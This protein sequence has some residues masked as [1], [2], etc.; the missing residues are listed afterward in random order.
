MTGK[1]KAELD[2]GLATAALKTGD[3]GLARRA[4]E[5]GL[6]R[7]PGDRGL[8]RLLLL[9]QMSLEDGAAARHTEARLAQ[10]K[11]DGDTFEVL[12]AAALADNRIGDARTLVAR[13]MREERVAAPALALARARIALNEGDVEAAKAILIMAIEAHPD[14]PGLRPLMTE[15]L[16]A[17]GGAAYARDVLSRLGQA[18]VNPAPEDA[19]SHPVDLDAP[20]DAARGA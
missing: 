14:A 16:I 6:S 15:T 19:T 4:A 20:E 5:T 7:H 8:L 18:P 9:A 2:A 11:L 10:E 13:A 17:S 1:P 12:I 3:P